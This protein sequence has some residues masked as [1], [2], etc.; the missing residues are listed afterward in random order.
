MWQCSPRY[1]GPGFQCHLGLG[2]WLAV[3]ALHPMHHWLTNPWWGHL[4]LHLWTPCCQRSWSVPTPD[5][6]IIFDG[7]CAVAYIENSFKLSSLTWSV[8]MLHPVHKAVSGR[9]VLFLLLFFVL[10]LFCYPWSKTLLKGFVV[11]H[12]ILAF[13]ALRQ[14]ARGVDMDRRLKPIF[15]RWKPRFEQLTND[16]AILVAISQHI[17]T[18]IRLKA[19]HQPSEPSDCGVFPLLSQ[20]QLL[21]TLG[22]RPHQLCKKMSNYSSQSI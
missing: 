11:H 1:I 10:H 5:R 7:D 15:T 18:Y 17:S 3:F 12:N 16:L 2:T 20:A 8:W 19:S 9:L 21:G 13:F 6:A 4:R 22:L 14:R